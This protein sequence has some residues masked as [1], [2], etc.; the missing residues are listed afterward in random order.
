MTLQEIKD[1]VYLDF[2]ASFKN[3]ITPLKKSFF[4]VL[5]NAISGAFQLIY[6]YLDNVQKDSFLHMC[7]QSRVLNYFAPLNRLT[8]KEPTKSTGIVTFTGIDGSV[9]P[10]GTKIIYNSN[11]EYETTAEGTISSGFVNINCQSVGFGSLNN[12]LNNIALFLIVPVSGVDNNALSS[13]GFTGAIDEETVE[14]LRTRCI[15]KQ[16]DTPQIDNGNYY[17]SLAT[18]VPNVKAAFIS[19]LKN[20]VGTFGITILTVSN[21]GVPVQADIDDV[22]DYFV[23]ISAVPIYATAEY[24]LPVILN[25]D[26][27]IL[28]AVDNEE[29]RKSTEQL[30]RD[31]LYLFQKPNSTFSFLGLSKVLQN[32]NARLISPL[33]TDTQVIAAD[34]VIDLGT[35]TWS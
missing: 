27:E 24:F 34:E 15:V 4:E 31:Y 20:G 13:I 14:S 3:A 25:Q 23:S 2:V 22:E 10:V 8:L 7:T 29:N 32:G 18:T 5:T 35:L 6:I 16:G 17:K 1:R 9:I 11:L 12:T 26:F 30:I 19:E 28:L 33:P 21:N